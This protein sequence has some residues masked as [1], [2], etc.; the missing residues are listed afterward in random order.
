M[1]QDATL[2]T[3][4]ASGNI[5]II[6]LALENPDLFYETDEERGWSPLHYA[7]NYSKHKVVDLILG[8]GVSPNIES[9][10][11]NKDQGVEWSI[12]DELKENNSILNVKDEIAYPM[13][14]AEGK[15]RT[16]IIKNL[17]NKGGRFYESELSLHQAVQMEDI[18]EVDMMLEDDRV[19]INARDKRG[20]MP[21]H[22]AIELR[23]I[24]LIKLLIDNNAN[25]NGVTFEPEPSIL[26]AWEIANNNNDSELLSYLESIGAEKICY[27]T[28]NR[29]KRIEGIYEK[30]KKYDLYKELEFEDI[31]KQPESFLGRLFEAKI[32]KNERLNRN[33][34]LLIEKERKR[35]IAEKKIKDEQERIKRS[36]VI[37]W[38][39][40]EDPFALKGETLEYDRVCQA[41]TFFMDIVG[42]SKK[43]TNKQKI[44]TEQ[45]VSIVRSTEGYEQANRQ[46]KLIILPTG[47]GM[48]LVFFNSIHAAFKC[49]IDVG[50]RIFQNKDIGLR[51]GLDT[52]PVV[53]VKDIND[54]PNVSG[55]GINMA[56]RCMDAGD[57]DHILISNTVYQYVNEMDIPGLE[58]DDWG[59]VLVKHG[60]MIHMW[61]AYGPGFG[62]KEFPHWRG[63]KKIDFKK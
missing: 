18:D 32:N 46:G 17:R 16:R 33:K 12:N 26:N 8:S 36:R 60:A 49:A 24:E 1:M 14:V 21:L 30:K 48:A 51:I 54:N 58:F 56:Q 6:R 4:A 13:D 7:S 50:K 47:D 2:H 15:N 45:L 62:R 43:T 31:T 29:P 52:G 22:Y 40:G 38:K 19:K 35:K 5:K 10:P 42:Y 3:L 41:T 57:N 23:N 53:P 28:R 59:S 34:A 25:V 61:T 55:E 44:V 9:I 63:T 11:I 39:W 20:W 37:S 27:Q